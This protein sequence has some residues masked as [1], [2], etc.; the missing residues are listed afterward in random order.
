MKRSTEPKVSR[1]GRLL[2]LFVLLAASNSGFAEQPI[3]DLRQGNLT[4]AC[5]DFLD[6]K[7]SRVQPVTTSVMPAKVQTYSCDLRQTHS[8]CRRYSLLEGATETLAELKEG[9]ESMGGRFE[10]VACPASDQAGACVDIVRNYHKPDV[11]YDNVY[12]NG[13]GQL[14]AMPQQEHPPWTPDTMAEIC[15]NLGGELQVR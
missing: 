3:C 5:R 10:P 2:A 1:R 12:Y 7:R 13:T 8:L 11:I 4:S 14:D 9:C 6:L 15:E